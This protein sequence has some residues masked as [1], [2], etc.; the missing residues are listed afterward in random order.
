M[1][2]IHGRRDPFWD[3]DGTAARRVR[4]RHG[5]VAVIAFAAAFAAVVGAAT[6]WAGLFGI[7]PAG[8][9]TV[10][11]LPGFGS[12]L[13]SLGGM[14]MTGIAMVLLFVML[15]SATVGVARALRGPTE[16]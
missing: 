3:V 6:A 2:M 7:A 11:S 16:A 9:P 5:F 13:G 12:D 8:I 10:G 1:R 15:L 4:R 14:A